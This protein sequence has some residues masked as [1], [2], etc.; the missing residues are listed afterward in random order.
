M[1][2]DLI[3]LIDAIPTIES[4]FRKV[5]S[6]TNNW[7][8]SGE[9][10]YDNPEF[11][12]WKQAI[13]C[14]LQD[15]FDRTQDRYIWSIINGA[16]IIRQFTGCNGSERKYF[17]ELKGALMAIKKNIPKYYPATNEIQAIQREE[18]S[19]KRV[20]IFISHSSNDVE[21]V[22][23]FVDL[24][25]DMGLTNKDLFC[26]SIPDYGIPLN[27]DIYDYLE[28]LF[29][30]YDIYVIFMLS[31]NY[32]NSPACLNEM[33]AAWVLKSNYTSIL[34]PGFD[35]KEIKGS[36]NP[37]K[38]GFKLDDEDDFL[39]RRLEELIFILAKKTGKSIPMIRW[40][41][42]RN[43]FIEDIKSK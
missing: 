32:Y 7:F 19:T 10:I 2:S 13:I 9:F 41:K 21:I 20:K 28:S 31:Q 26:S 17:N 16:G 27:E 43:S 15:I 6:P 11:I 18:N 22:S 38:I 33:G 40:E 25:A 1:K 5:K 29:N 4:K 36:V 12:E 34:L 14:E 24:L 30:E 39:K 35:Y 3:E 42:K 8:F 23:K 37:D